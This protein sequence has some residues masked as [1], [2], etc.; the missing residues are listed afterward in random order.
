M[1]VTYERT[2]NNRL[3]NTSEE[4]NYGCIEEILEDIYNC[5][6]VMLKKHSKVFVLRFDIRFPKDTIFYDKN[7]IYDFNYN[8]KRILNREKIQGGH[9]VDPLLISVAEKHNEDHNHYHYL[10]LVNGN[11]H[12]NSINILEKINRLWSR[13]IGSNQKGLVDFCY[14]HG[15]NGIMLDKNSYDFEKQ[16]NEAFYQASYLAKIRGK[17]N[18]DKGSWLVKKS[19]YSHY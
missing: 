1:R 15:R 6:E 19:R 18:P 13:M 10:L 8:L 4:K 2:F 14:K 7:K 9:R 11:A 16:Y 5:F 12:H 3:I 17:Q